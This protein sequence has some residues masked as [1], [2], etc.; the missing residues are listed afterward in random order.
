MEITQLPPPNRYVF[1]SAYGGAVDSAEPPQIH[2]LMRQLRIEIGA[3]EAKKSEDKFG[4]KFPVRGAKD[5]AQKLANALNKLNMEAPVVHQEITLLDT[6][7]IPGNER[8]SGN[9]VFRTLC[10][11]KSVVRLIAPDT[12]FIDVV[13]SGH[14]GDVDDKSGGKASTYAWKDAI[15][16]GLSIPHEDMVDTDDAEGTTGEDPVARRAKGGKA[17]AEGGEVEMEGGKGR[18]GRQAKGASSESKV[19][20]SDMGG[21]LVEG[22]ESESTAESDEKGLDYVLTQIKKSN[23]GNEMESIR[24]AIKSGVLAL[25]GADKLRA[26]ESWVARKGVLQKEGKW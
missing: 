1:Q 21:V 4:P 2:N 26:T 25:H 7:K 20:Q 11:V 17:A 3:V 15:L 24:T 23:S 16:K 13:G 12:S 18:R 19:S 8:Q 6:D 9:P 10:H 14:G 5:L 22:L